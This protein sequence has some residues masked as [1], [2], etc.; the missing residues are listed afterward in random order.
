[1]IAFAFCR[2]HFYP[3]SFKVSNCTG[4]NLSANSTRVVDLVYYP[5]FSTSR[6]EAQLT[7]L[8]SNN[9][10]QNLSLSIDIPL[11]LLAK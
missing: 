5:D 10:S 6:I 1:M 3:L 7:I 9:L 2:Y 4:F 8:A 11:K